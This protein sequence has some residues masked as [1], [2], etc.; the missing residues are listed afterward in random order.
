MFM[1]TEEETEVTS[2]GV[3]F[4]VCVFGCLNMWHA[5]TK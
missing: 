2:V 4:H 3:P 5:L 1:E